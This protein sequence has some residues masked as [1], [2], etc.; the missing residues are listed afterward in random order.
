[1]FEEEVARNVCVSVQQPQQHDVPF[2]P[3]VQVFFYPRIATNDQL[4]PTISLAAAAS[5]HQNARTMPHHVVLGNVRMT[6]RVASWNTNSGYHP[7]DGG[8][9]MT[10]GVPNN[11]ND[12]DE[13]ED[14]WQAILPLEAYVVST[15]GGETASGP[16]QIPGMCLRH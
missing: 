14:Y 1:M 9:T 16:V 4:L 15:Q 6:V 5:Y 3:A 12:D 7:L 2:Q 8:S 10:P 11:N 13:Q